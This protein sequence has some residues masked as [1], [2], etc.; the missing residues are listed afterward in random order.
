MCLILLR[1]YP[2]SVILF[3]GSNDNMHLFPIQEWRRLRSNGRLRTSGPYG[4]DIHARHNLF[5]SDLLLV[6]ESGFWLWRFFQ[7]FLYIEGYMS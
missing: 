3:V 2:I 1:N 4:V 7:V 5:G 6:Q